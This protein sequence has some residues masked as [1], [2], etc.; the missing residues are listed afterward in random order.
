MPR[1]FFPRKDLSALNWSRNFRDRIVADPDK[2]HFTPQQAADYSQLHDDFAQK[3]RIGLN[4][5][6]ATRSATAGKNAA[7]RALEKVLRKMVKRIQGRREIPL[8]DKLNA[9]IRIRK[10]TQTRW[11][12]PE[13]AP[14]VR[15]LRVAVNQMTIQLTDEPAGRFGKPPHV[16]FATVFYHVGE[17]F[18]VAQVK[19]TFAQ[20]TTRARFTVT[21]PA[22]IPAGTTVWFTATWHNRRYSSPFAAPVAACTSYGIPVQTT[23]HAAAA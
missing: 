23:L 8:A 12:R 1:D 9:G 7:R 14:G 6:T 22:S 5:S 11:P 18:P 19:W 13:V 20:Q 16:L 17:K 4:P 21:L 10:A 2:Y 3:L 15:I